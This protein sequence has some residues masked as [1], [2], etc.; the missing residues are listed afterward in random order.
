MH[1]PTNEKD[2]F[3]MSQGNQTADKAT[4]Q[5]SRGPLPLGALTP[6]LDL[7][8]FKPHYIGQD[9]VWAHEREFS[10]T[11]TNSIWKSNTY[12]T[13]SFPKA[14][15]CPILKHL[16]EGTYYGRDALMDL[17]RPHLKDPHLQRTIQKIIQ[18]RQI[19]DK[20]NYKIMWPNRKG[21]AI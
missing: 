11:E 10:N 7:S 17:S 2:S 9:D 14:L 12:S 16:H 20:N 21:S 15:V 1:C 19:C 4:R 18:V 8:E 6:H 3:Q 5:G 13:I